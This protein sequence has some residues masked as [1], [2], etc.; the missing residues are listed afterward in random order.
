MVGVDRTAF[1]HLFLVLRSC[2]IEVNHTDL[3][4]DDCQFARPNN[5]PHQVQMQ[6]VK[7]KEKA[8]RS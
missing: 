8:V 4:Q 2:E 7:E 5:A 3:P 1:Q 6:D